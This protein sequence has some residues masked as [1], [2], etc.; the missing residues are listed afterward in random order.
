V[1][2]D[3]DVQELGAEAP[4]RVAA[5]ASDTVRGPLDTH[6]PLD[7]QRHKV[8]RSSVLVAVGPQPWLEIADAV[9]LQP[10]QNAAYGGPAQIELPR[11]PHPGPTLSS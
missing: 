9:Q 11:D 2:V 3:G 8:P 5:V 7:V 6:Q 1:V 4:D 10:A